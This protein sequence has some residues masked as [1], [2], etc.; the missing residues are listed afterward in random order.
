[1]T[2]PDHTPVHASFSIE[3]DYPHPPA[4]VF[5]AFSDLNTKRRWF[6]EGEGFTV[7]EY[8]MDFRE[9]GFER[10]RFAA[11]GGVEG[12]ND[13]VYLDIVPDARIVTAYTMDF[14]GARISS[15]LLT[16]TFAARGGGTRLTLTEQGYYLGNS[17][18]PAGREAGT[19]ELLEALAKALA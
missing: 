4:K 5:A 9:G 14:A 13:T 1:M 10:C 17:D 15:S 6:A 11:P 3:R 19:R 7:H 16:L 8:S 12:R 2:L 18:G